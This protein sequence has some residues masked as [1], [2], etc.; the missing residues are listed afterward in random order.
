MSCMQAHKRAV[1]EANRERRKHKTP[2]HIK[3]AHKAGKKKVRRRWR[4][5]AWHAARKVHRA[6]QENLHSGCSWKL[7][8]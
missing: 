4:A 7:T 2:K 6:H 5:I 8:S 1:K 3:K